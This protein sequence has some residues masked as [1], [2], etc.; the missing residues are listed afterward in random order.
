MRV[1]L[2]IPL[3]IYEICAAINTSLPPVINSNIP[4]THICTDT[5]ECQ[6]SDLF[7]ALPG[8]NDSGE[9]YIDEAISRKCFV[10]SQSHKRG[11]IHVDDTIEA[12]LGL[13][14]AYKSMIA[15]K[16]TVAITGS[17]GKSTT[18]KFTSTIL[19]QKFHVHSTIE[20]YN[21]HIGVPLTVFAMPKNTEV[22][23][24]EL[25]MNHRGEI[26]RLSRAVNPDIAAITTIGTAHIG[27][28]GSREEIAKAKLEIIDGMHGGSILLPFSE[29]LLSNINGALYVERGS[30]L[31][32]FSLNDIDSGEYSYFSPSKSIY[33]ISFFDNREHL[34][35]DLSFAL[36]I[37]DLLN[38]TQKE[39]LDGVNTIK[40]SC[41]RQRFI[42][43]DDFTIFDDS[44][45][46]SLESIS[47]DLKFI[48][49]LNRPCGAFLGDVLELG[50]NSGEIHE[51]IGTITARLHIGRLYL[52]GKYAEHIAYGALKEGM[53][54]ESIFINS[55]I[56][57]PELSVEQIYRHHTPGE[58]I[59]FKA[60]HKLRLDKIADLIKSERNKQ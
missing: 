43:V 56:S 12:I 17:V 4:I 58:I 32:H 29:P 5:R 59:L 35:I 42:D 31:S 50:S 11:V 60:S 48:S 45:N 33:G 20:N 54:K 19:K 16:H 51:M 47:A 28:L 2:D 3:S 25:G 52:Y 37:A 55:D 24:C 7:I 44:Y 27:N 18:V 57:S 34:L 30:S 8:E 39:M 1:K 10:I 26:S 36:A 13:T 46:A 21:N 15:P 53:N 49:S 41:L 14:T 22:L 23:V 38:L 40:E 9:K 6:E